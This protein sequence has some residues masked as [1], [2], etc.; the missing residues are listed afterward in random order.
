MRKNTWI[1]IC[2]IIV[3]LTTILTGFVIQLKYHMDR[4]S[5]VVETWGLA[6][7]SWS[8]LHKLSIVVLSLLM[9]FHVIS[10]WKWYKTI[11][12]R[13]L[14]ARNRQTM[15]LSVF[16]IITAVTG[17]T[18]WFAGLVNE[19]ASSGAALFRKAFIEIHD[20]IAIIL[21]IYIILHVVKRMKRI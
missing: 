17:Y 14:I 2:L 8:F 18:A 12:T 9:L 3:S 7:N 6:Y 1:N 19:G 20:K 5:P 10:H 21:T 16:F 15:I 11:I 4:L 13:K